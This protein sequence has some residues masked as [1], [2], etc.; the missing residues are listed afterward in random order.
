MTAFACSG[1]G[2]TSADSV[3]GS[4]GEAVDPGMG[5]AGNGLGGSSGSGSGGD[6][7]K[8]S[9]GGVQGDAGNGAGG[10]LVGDSGTSGS[11]SG[12]SDASGGTDTEGGAPNSGGQ[13][14]EGG[15]RDLEPT[16]YCSESTKT[17]CYEFGAPYPG[18]YTCIPTG[19]GGYCEAC[20]DDGD[21]P[22]HL[23]CNKSN[24]DGCEV[25]FSDNL[26]N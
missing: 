9:T 26:C 13:G 4:A 24:A 18:V 10:E 3:A 21:D 25:V 22:T 23:D 2:K 16:P 12:G 20:P 11:G 14:G 15:E 17:F 7:G 1:E 8:P 6:A 19:G 5:E